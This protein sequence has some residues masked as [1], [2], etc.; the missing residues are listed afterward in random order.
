MDAIPG[1]HAHAL[2]GGILPWE[3][4][5]MLGLNLLDELPMG[6]IP[7]PFTGCRVPQL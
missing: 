6:H 5:D 2:I 7:E 1:H 3:M 4:I